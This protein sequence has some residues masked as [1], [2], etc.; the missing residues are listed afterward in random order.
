MTIVGTERK[1][2]KMSKTSRAEAMQRMWREY[3]MSSKKRKGELLD[4]YCTSTGI[5]RKHAIVQVGWQGAVRTRQKKAGR[6]AVY[7]SLLGPLATV[8]RASGWCCA[9]LLHPVLMEMVAGLER[10]G[11]MEVGAQTR[12]LL[13]RMSCSTLKRQLRRLPCGKRRRRR[14]PRVRA[15]Q[16]RVALSW[17]QPKPRRVGTF[18]ADLVEHNGGNSSGEYLYTVNAVDIVSSWRRKRACLGKLRHRIVRELDEVRSGL[19]YAIMVLDID[20]DRALLNETVAVWAERHAIAMTRSRPYHK[21]DNAH[22]EQKNG[23]DVRGLVGYRRYD[24]AAQQDLLNQLYEIDDLHINLFVPV[25]KLIRRTRNDERGTWCKSY[26][27]ARTPLQRVLERPAAEVSAVQKRQLQAL[28]DRL[29][30]L[31]LQDQK[32]RLLTLLAHTRSRG[33]LSRDILQHAA[34]HGRNAGAPCNGHVARACARPL[35]AAQ[36]S[37]A[38]AIIS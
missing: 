9:E 37:A 10:R 16:A 21:N 5:K 13:G 6:P 11:R 12:A 34:A 19:P 2:E 17:G 4:A 31:D 24:T 26:D 27:T 35:P 30:P 29:D 14:P 20:N 22:V 36:P 28:A 33:Q 7:G 38:C 15:L 25:R 8:W 32:E 23:T 1:E 3:V 18:E